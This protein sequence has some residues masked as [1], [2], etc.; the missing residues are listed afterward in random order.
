MNASDVIFVIIIVIIIWKI[1]LRMLNEVKLCLLDTTF[2]T[3]YNN[4]GCIRRI[5]QTYSLNVSFI[6]VQ[7]FSF[8]FLLL[9]FTWLQ[10]K[11]I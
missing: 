3:Q 1:D 4:V 8:F 10:F 11:N 6:F 7:Y 2:F 9:F 5:S